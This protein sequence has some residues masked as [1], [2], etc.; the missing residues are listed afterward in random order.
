MALHRSLQQL[1]DARTGVHAATRRRLSPVTFCH[2]SYEDEDEFH[3]A[4]HGTFEQFLS[5]LPNVEVG[6][7]DKDRC[8]GGGGVPEPTGPCTGR[9]SR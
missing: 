3:D 8:V 7:D 4:L 6:R 5:A 9:C 2:H 1:A